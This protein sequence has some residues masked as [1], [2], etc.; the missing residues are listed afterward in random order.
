MYRMRVKDLK[1]VESIIVDSK[2]DLLI[3]CDTDNGDS[4]QEIK[5]QLKKIDSDFWGGESK[6]KLKIIK[7]NAEAI[8]SLNDSFMI[9]LNSENLDNLRSIFGDN[10]IKLS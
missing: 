9:D 6:V 8:I 10:K 5:L 4:L 2:K 1:A 7:N 3:I